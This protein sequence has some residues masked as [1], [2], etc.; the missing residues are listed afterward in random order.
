MIESKLY[1]LNIVSS[2]GSSSLERMA[3]CHWQ[4]IEN[5]GPTGRFF[6]ILSPL[7]QPSLP[8]TQWKSKVSQLNNVKDQSPSYAMVTIITTTTRVTAMDTEGMVLDL[9]VRRNDHTLFQHRRKVFRL[10]HANYN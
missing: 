10:S 5:E 7:N 9:I 8:M 3:T 2:V 1:K 4:A 6:D